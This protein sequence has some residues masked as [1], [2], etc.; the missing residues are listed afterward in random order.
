[1]VLAASIFL[2]LLGALLALFAV[3]LLMV[4]VVYS[5]SELQGWGAGIL[6]IVTSVASF[7]IIAA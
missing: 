5:E 4:G 1:M 6:L 7:I 2:G 3:V